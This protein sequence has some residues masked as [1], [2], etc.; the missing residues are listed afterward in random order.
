MFSNIEEKRRGGIL[1]RYRRGL[2]STR[3]YLGLNLMDLLLGEG[4][5]AINLLSY[6]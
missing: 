1:K 3:K 6:Y 4:V 2:H 5:V